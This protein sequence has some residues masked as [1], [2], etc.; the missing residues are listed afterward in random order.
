MRFIVESNLT[1]D[2]KNLEP[3][4]SRYMEQSVHKVVNKS[5]WKNLS[6]GLTLY[7]DTHPD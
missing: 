2:L 4:A 1:A 7:Q 5:M 6:F 3:V